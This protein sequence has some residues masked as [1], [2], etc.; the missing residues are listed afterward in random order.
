MT[1]EERARKAGKEA[2]RVGA[3]FEPPNLKRTIQRR[4]RSRLVMAFSTTALVVVAAIG[5][6][7]L[8]MRTDTETVPVGTTTTTTTMPDQ[9]ATTIPAPATTTPVVALP[10]EPIYGGVLKMA[11]DID[12]LFGW[13]DIDGSFVPPTIN[14]LLDPWNAS[15]VARLTVPGAYRIDA[16]TGE[17]APWV[18]TQIPRAENGGVVVAETV[19]VTYHIRPE[20][21]WA[22]DTPI[23]AEDFLFTH[24]LIMR[25]DLRIDSALREIHSLI[26]ADILV[27]NGKTI[28]FDLVTADPR[29]ERLFE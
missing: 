8:F 1:N 23:S 11:S 2:R 18:V 13:T 28:T 25:D 20:A 26:A 12:L 5:I 3:S 10:T 15:D 27:G 4:R 24:E 16:T 9:T 19:T 14:P 29:Y 7:A 22:D 6:G 17:L 21:V